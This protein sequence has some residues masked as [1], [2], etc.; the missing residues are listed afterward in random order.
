LRGLYLHREQ[1]K[2]GTN[3]HITDI[4]ALSGIRTHDRSVRVS[5]YSSFLR[6]RGQCDQHILFEE[7]SN[8]VYTLRNTFLSQLSVVFVV[9]L[10]S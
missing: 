4:H 5:E 6:P 8:M 3:A 7:L 10:I 9:S 1:H 2:H